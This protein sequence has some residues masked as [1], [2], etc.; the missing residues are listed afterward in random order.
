MKAI[1]TWHSIDESGSVISVTRAQFKRH[2][3]WLASGRVRVVPL[4]EIVTDD[5][6]SDAVALTF[7]DGFTSFSS[8]AVPLLADRG[9]TAT[10]FVVAGKVGGTNNWNGTGER[11][12]G[13]P[14]MPLMSW[15]A[16]N[17][18]RESG[19]D[20]G[21]H[22]LNHESLTLAPTHALPEEVQRCGELIETSTGYL[23]DCFAYPYGDHDSVAVA[24]VG[25]MFSLACTTKFDLIKP[26]SQR[27]ILPRL[28]TYYFRDNTVLQAW[29]TAKFNT[30]LGLRKA[31]R[32]M[33]ARVTRRHRRNE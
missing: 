9:L 19:F 14:S 13:V 29:G 22:G 23:P 3:D 24:A 30:Y 1:L 6:G 8:I 5:D 16:I 17:A 20:I 2:V 25:S 28:D 15:D 7:D 12:G 33:R 10:V 32:A 31:G 26:S 18:A 11:E 27:L 4:A 21:A